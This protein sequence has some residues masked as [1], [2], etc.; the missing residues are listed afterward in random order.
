MRIE[1]IVTL[2]TIVVVT[3]AKPHG[4]AH[5]H[6]HAVVARDARPD[7]TV[8]APAVIQTITKFE[9]EGHGI[10]EEDVRQG[11]LNGTLQWAR[12]GTLSTLTRGSVALPTTSPLPSPPATP[13]EK[14]KPAEAQSELALS[15]STPTEQSPKPQ[16]KPVQ[17]VDKPSD[18]PSTQTAPSPGASSPLDASPKTAD[19]LV[20]ENGKCSTC[21]I[22]F[23]SG[24]L[25]CSAFPNGYGAMPITHENLDG[26]SGIQDP[27]FSGDA[28]FDNIRT[29]VS[30][31]CSGG[32]CC[33]PGSFCSY[34]CPNPYLKLSFPK[35]QGATGQSVGGL[36]CNANG[37]L[38][39]AD[40]SLGK[41][42]C[43]PDSA[44]MKVKVQN[45]LQKSVSICRTD[46]P[47]D[48]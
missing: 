22:E 7:R 20:D 29:V 13:E 25:P 21:D 1:H 8:Y 27:G 12:D 35:K 34:G 5:R 32:S 38:E 6:A 37:M 30:G 17:P 45:K 4:H 44:H 39:M 33:T 43:G 9:L 28:G 41:T 14:P 47:G 15:T 2:A 11:L 31:S 18:P 40:G 48:D 23:P 36:Y 16:V 24:K 10:S 26:W 19:Q 46:Y 3:I 42:L